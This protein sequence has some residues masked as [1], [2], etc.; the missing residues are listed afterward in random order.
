MSRFEI[1]YSMRIV[2]HCVPYM[3][4]V[5]LCDEFNC[6]KLMSHYALQEKVCDKCH[7]ACQIQLNV[8]S[9]MIVT[10]CDE[11]YLTLYDECHIM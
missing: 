8:I 6:I 3:M 11:C 9:K 4:N 10:L 7:T 2:S 1:C 5:S